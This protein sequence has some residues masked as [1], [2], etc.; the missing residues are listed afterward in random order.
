MQQTIMSWDGTERPIFT[1]GMKF[2][3][4]DK[5]DDPRLPAVELMKRCLPIALGEGRGSGFDGKVGAAL[6]FAAEALGGLSGGSILTA[7]NGYTGALT[8]IMSMS[9]PGFGEGNK[10]VAG[11]CALLIGRW[12]CAMNL[13]LTQANFDVSRTVLHSSG[14]PLVCEGQIT[15]QPYKWMTEKELED[16]FFFGEGKGTGKASK[17]VK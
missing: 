8:N 1:V 15:L 2:V 7:P 9:N 4:T 12:F 3:A 11:T 16:C 6:D 17:W 10:R 5:G 13:I 14:K